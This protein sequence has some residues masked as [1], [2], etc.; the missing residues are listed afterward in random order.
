RGL[1]AHARHALYVVDRVAHQGH[2]FDQRA[3]LDTESRPHFAHA[4]PLVAHRVPQVYV[5][6]DQLHEVLVAGDDRDVELHPG[7]AAGERSDRIVGLVAL[8]HDALDAE[9]FDDT[10]DVRNLNDQIVRR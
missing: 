2:H 10:M 6:T 7:R 3:G 1:F 9:S 4:G 5:G 8:Q